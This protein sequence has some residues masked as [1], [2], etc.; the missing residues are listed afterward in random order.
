[1]Q[2][3][4]SNAS[5]C[6]ARIS[7]NAH[8]LTILIS[9]K[10]PFSSLFSSK[11]RLLKPLD[12]SSCFPCESDANDGKIWYLDELTRS[13]VWSRVYATLGSNTLLKEVAMD[14]SGETQNILLFIGSHSLGWSTP[15]TK[16]SP[17]IVEHF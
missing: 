4:L 3:I 11:Q 1:M 17:K 6:T 13:R 12:P 8:F 15:K 2:D 5:I 9:A 7:P 16:E 10:R 14:V